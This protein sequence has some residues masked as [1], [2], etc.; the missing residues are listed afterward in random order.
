M[1][2]RCVETTLEKTTMPCRCFFRASNVLGV[3]DLEL[4]GEKKKGR[5]FFDQGDCKRTTMCYQVNGI[6]LEI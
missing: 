3:V 6:C 1:F 4:D 5:R 2:Q